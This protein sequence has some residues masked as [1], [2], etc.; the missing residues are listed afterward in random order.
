MMTTHRFR[1]ALLA[2]GTA[3]CL[4]AA[5]VGCSADDSGAAPAADSVTLTDAWGKAAEAGSMTAVFGTLSN[6]AGSPVTLTAVTT[7]VSPRA[8]LHEMASDGSGSM[9][10]REKEG[11]VEIPAGGDSV[12]QPGGEHVMLF[13]LS[14]PLKAGD[15]LSMTLTF[16]DGSTTDVHAQVRDFSG[17]Q[18]NYSESSGEAT[19]HGG[20][21]TE[22][23]S[24]MAEHSGDM[25]GHTGG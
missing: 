4:G 25:N 9:S 15:Q 20:D 19:E 8:E 17:A 23:G 18:E 2:G 1:N 5:L 3:L 10:M 11:G 14:S 22:H 16:S 12:L 13:D 6:S 7:D 24:D 21:T